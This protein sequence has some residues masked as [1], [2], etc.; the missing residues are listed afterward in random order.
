MVI[1]AEGEPVTEPPA[2]PDVPSVAEQEKQGILYGSAAI[3][4]AHSCDLTEVTRVETGQPLPLD[5]AAALVLTEGE[6]AVVLDLA[7]L[8]IPEDENPAPAQ[9]AGREQVAFVRPPPSP[10]EVRITQQAVRVEVQG[11]VSISKARIG[12]GLRAVRVI[13]IQKAPPAQEA[14]QEDD[15]EE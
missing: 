5:N 11:P 15:T 10:V 12:S 1:E 2:L 13:N 6:Q 3:R 8:D 14:A 9:P 4:F 7:E